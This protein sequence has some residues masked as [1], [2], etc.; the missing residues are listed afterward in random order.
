MRH[1]YFRSLC[2]L[3]AFLV[4]NQLTAQSPHL[5]DFNQ[6]GLDHQQRAMLILG[7]WAVGNIA[8][9]AS[10]RGSTSGSTRYFHE[11]NIYWNLVNLG[12]AG[13]GYYSSIQQ[14]PASFDLYTSMQRHASFQKVLLFNAGLDI[15]YILG[16]L[17]LTERARRPN[18]NSDQLKGFGRS[19]IL[20][21]SFLFAFDLVNY[22]IS[23]SRNDQL[24]LLSSPS[25]LGL[26]YTF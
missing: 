7:G 14:D 12:I 16:G 25:G 21:G 24:Q 23:N 4:I 10:L 18:V 6:Q 11:M 19:I 9:G 15:G 20:Q 5:L 17:Y 8:L 1:I 26:S 2:C 22:F 13:F 3:F